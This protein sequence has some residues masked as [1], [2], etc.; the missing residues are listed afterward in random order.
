MHNWTPADWAGFFTALG[1]LIAGIAAAAVAI[2]NA[3]RDVKG[4]LADHEEQSQ[5][6]THALS[7]QIE[8]TRS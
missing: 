6:R 3:L 4:A 2:I 1:G 5:K 7:Q 8:E